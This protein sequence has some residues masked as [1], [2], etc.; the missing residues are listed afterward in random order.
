MSQCERYA[1]LAGLYLDGELG[2]AEEAELFAH[3]EQCE[4]CRN[5][6]ELMKAVS[7]E[8]TEQRA[9]EGFAKSVMDAVGAAASENKR[10]EARRKRRV[11]SG[12]SKGAAAKYAALAACLAVVIAAGVKLASPSDGAI[13]E[14]V[15]AGFK[16]AG[17]EYAYPAANGEAEEA[18]PESI[19]NRDIAEADESAPP[20]SSNSGY[21]GVES[22]TVTSGN[23]V[24]HTDDAEEIAALADILRSGAAQPEAVPEGE[25]DYLVE[26]DGAEGRRELLVYAVDGELICETDNGSVWLAEGSEAELEDVLG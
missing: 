26:I 21:K 12:I 1:G 22:V 7:G 10:T 8:L 15:A 5:Y 19:E 17:A 18:A 24:T 11:L 13:P 9:P 14:S 20:A 3:L 16:C 23:T 25:A 6:F 4:S 2:R